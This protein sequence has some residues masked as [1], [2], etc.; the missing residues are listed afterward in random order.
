M[1]NGNVR[2]FAVRNDA[3]LFGILSQMMMWIWRKRWTEKLSE[4]IS[5]MKSLRQNP[6]IK[7][8]TGSKSPDLIRGLDLNP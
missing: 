2:A 3:I 6:E 4:K 8:K 7:V 1:L 5:G